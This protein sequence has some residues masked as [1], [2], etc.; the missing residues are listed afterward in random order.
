MPSLKAKKL[1]KPAQEKVVLERGSRLAN[2]IRPFSGCDGNGLCGA[3]SP[4]ENASGNHHQV[5]WWSAKFSDRY[6]L[7]LTKRGALARGNRSLLN[8]TSSHPQRPA[9]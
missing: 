2:S 4:Q 6:A 1:E 5:S 7:V 9:P 3:V 8:A